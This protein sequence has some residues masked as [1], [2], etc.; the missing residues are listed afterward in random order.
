MTR[1]SCPETSADMP[2]YVFQ[3]MSDHQLLFFTQYGNCYQLP[4]H[5]LEEQSRP[6]D[7]GTLLAGVLNGL[8]DGEQCV[9]GCW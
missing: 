1:R 7:R 3:T 4:V 2:R 6:R 5:Q 9:S 8:E